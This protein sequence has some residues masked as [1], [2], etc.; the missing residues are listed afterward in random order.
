MVEHSPSTVYRIL[1]DYLVPF[2]VMRESLQVFAEGLNPPE[3]NEYST[4]WLDEYSEYLR[5]TSSSAKCI[6]RFNGVV[7]KKNVRIWDT[8]G[9]EEHISV[10]TNAPCVMMCCA[11]SQERIRSLSFLTT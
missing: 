7:N 3:F 10:V 1:R 5:K 8:E 2:P 11:V 6:F 4:P 9:P